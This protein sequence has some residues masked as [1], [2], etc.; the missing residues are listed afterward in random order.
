MKK[1]LKESLREMQKNP[2]TGLPH[3]QQV[4]STQIETIFMIDSLITEIKNLNST[5]EKANKQNEKLEQTNLRLQYAMLIL[6]A[7]GTAVI[8][9][10]IMKVIINT[11]FLYFQSILTGI[12]NFKSFPTENVIVVISTLIAII[13]AIG[14]FIAEKKFLTHHISFTD[15]VKLKD[16]LHMELRDK[17]G[18]IKEIR[19]LK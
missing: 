2:T 18:N 8:V 5:I 1:E 12:I 6:T 3:N 14:S 16:S 17:D 11:V 7:I 19:D 9:Y 13:S 10:P 4:V 15:S